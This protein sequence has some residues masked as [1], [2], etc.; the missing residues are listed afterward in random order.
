M[1]DFVIYNISP[2]E[3]NAKGKNKILSEHRA[4]G[5]KKEQYIFIQQD[6]LKTINNDVYYTYISMIKKYEVPCL[7]YGFY[8]SV[9]RIFNGM[10][11][12][13]G[14]ITVTDDE[15]V[16]ILRKA[17]DAFICLDMN[18]I[19]D[20]LS[21]NEKLKAIEFDYFLYELYQREIFSIYSFYIEVLNSN[22]FFKEIKDYEIKSLKTSE[23]AKEDHEFFKENKIEIRAQVNMDLML[24]YIKEKH[25]L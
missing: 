1:K 8:K 24:D 20:D 25:I 17:I 2:D 22:E 7:F 23:N 12:P 18:S 21:F 14:K 19:P 11:N 3:N 5:K 9:N 13:I 4:K 6:D 15:Q 10:I 16:F